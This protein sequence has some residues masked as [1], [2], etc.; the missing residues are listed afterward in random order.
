MKITRHIYRFTL[1]LAFVCLSFSILHSQELN[2][3]ALL[4]DLQILSADSMEGRKAGSAGGQKARKLIVDRFVDLGILS[5][6]GGYEQPF[7]FQTFRSMQQYDNCANVIGYIPGEIEDIIVI[8]AHYDHI[9]TFEDRIFNGADDNASGSSALMA[10]A[11]YFSKKKPRHTLV[12]AAFDAEEVGLK[13]AT[14]FLAEPPQGLRKGM[15]RLNINMDMLGISE[16]NELW[17]S[18]THHNPGLRPV[19]EKISV[20]DGIKLSFGHDHPDHGPDDWTLQSDHGA[21]FREGIPHIYFGVE[22]HQHYHQDT[23]TF[24]NIHPD[25]F[26]KAAMTVLRAV[27]ALDKEDLLTLPSKR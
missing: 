7:S 4:S 18:G 14:L 1:S 23:D 5:F 20:P 13:G 21:F 19:L 24:E 25:F 10:M 3:A 17:A 8:S 16:K 2:K 9:G 6:E 26:H 15:I 12:F 27:I 22:D 11:E